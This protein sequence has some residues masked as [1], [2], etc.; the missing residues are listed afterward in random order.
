MVSRNHNGSLPRLCA[1]NEGQST[2]L[3]VAER[4]SISSESVVLGKHPVSSAARGSIVNQSVGTVER[5]D[6]LLTDHFNEIDSPSKGGRQHGSFVRSEAAMVF[7]SHYGPQ[8]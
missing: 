1:E 2:A 7:G 6:A 8:S 5:L 3:F 4:L